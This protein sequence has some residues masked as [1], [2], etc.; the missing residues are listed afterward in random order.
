MRLAWFQGDIKRPDTLEPMSMDEILALPDGDPRR[1]TLTLLLVP[2]DYDLSNMSGDD[3]DDRPA[4][5]NAEEP[6]PSTLPHG[7]VWLE[8]RAGDP[9]PTAKGAPA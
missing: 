5:C 1:P 9:F 7:A 3:W 2:D 4:D 6:T 8:I